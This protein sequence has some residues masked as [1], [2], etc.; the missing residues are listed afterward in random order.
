MSDESMRRRAMSARAATPTARRMTELTRDEAMRLL[1]SVSLGR[2]VFT[3]DALPTIRPVNHTLDDDGQ[4]VIRTH[5]GAALTRHTAGA[6]TRGGVVVAYEAEQIDP[7]THL[8]W[9]V[10]VTGYARL[11]RDPVRLARYQ[12]LLEPWVDQA[13]DQAVCIRPDIVTG[14]LLTAAPA[15]LD[16]ERA[17]SDPKPR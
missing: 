7:D 4:I 1:G 12:A 15:A 14:F 9:S 6:G 5:H 3:Q 13:M 11:I 10:I 8:G 2:I 16:G 17:Q